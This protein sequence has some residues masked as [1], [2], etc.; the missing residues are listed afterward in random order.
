[1]YFRYLLLSMC[2]LLLGV[3]SSA[4]VSV[5]AKIDSIS[6]LVGEQT[7]MEVAV[8]ARKGAKIVWP[9][10]K[11]SHYLVPGVEI[12]DVADG[13]TSEVDNNVRISKRITL[14]SFDEKLYPIPG[15][16]VKVDGKPYEANQLAL[17]V[18]TIDV[19]TLH[20][21]QFYPPKTVQ[22]N[23]FLWSEWSGLFWM[24]VLVLA[25]MGGIFYLYIRLRENKPIIAKIRI[26]KKVLPHQRAL[27]AMEKIKAEHLERSDDQKT[28]YT[29]LTDA[30]RQYINERFGFN[31]MEMTSSEIIERLQRNG[32]KKMIGELKE[33]FE[34]A[35]L[36][37]FAK[38]STLINENDL[39]LVNAINF[40]DQT[41][42]NEQTVEEKVAPELTDQDRKT[43]S[44]RKLIKALLWGGA[45]VMAAITAYV[46]YGACMLLM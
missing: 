6:I 1:M 5:E 42:T 2:C 46:I 45:I 27:S 33:L 17:K 11:P 15:M 23:P 16:K 31:A 8:T 28:Y 35:D 19:D 30:L 37:K 7:N 4:Q 14:T 44:Q 43:R 38:Y 9:N 26:V 29:Q 40:I 41:K 25:L 24:S 3:K 21:N 39:N 32:D 20:P 18:M 22:N 36:V 34:T 12:I 13:D 10:I